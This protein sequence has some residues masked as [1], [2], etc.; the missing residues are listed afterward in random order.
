MELTRTS[1]ELA[2][3]WMGHEIARD[4]KGDHDG[5]LLDYDRAISIDPNRA[6]AYFSHG[7]AS[8]EE[9]GG[10]SGGS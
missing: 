6:D 7:I 3:A 2:E 5:A 9:E 1:I 4:A 10:R 8:G